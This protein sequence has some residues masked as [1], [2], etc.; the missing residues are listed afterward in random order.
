M[1]KEKSA[2]EVYKPVVP[3]PNRL[4]SNKSNAQ[5]EKFVEMFNQV[6]NQHA[7]S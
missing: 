6:K 1:K 7:T 4:K 2:E 3:F 5:M